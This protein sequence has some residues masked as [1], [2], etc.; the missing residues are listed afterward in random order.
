MF[1]LAFDAKSALQTPTQ[2]ASTES[3]A[4]LSA[5]TASATSQAQRQ[6]EKPL[7]NFM[8]A[9]GWRWLILSASCILISACQKP[10]NTG[11][12]GYAEGEYLYLA[13][14]VA[15]RLQQLSVQSGQTVSAGMTLAEFA[16]GSE[17]L[18]LQEA[19]QRQLSAAALAS[20]SD[21]GRR[22]SEIAALQ[23]QQLAAQ[24]QVALAE[25]E[26]ARQQQLL[27]Q[28]YISAARVD[29]AQTQLNLA[30][31]KLSEIRANLQTARLP[32]RSDERQAQYATAAA[33]A[34]LSAQQAWRVEQKRLN[35]PAAGIITQV[36][37]RA[38]EWVNA[39]QPVLA[40]LPATHRKA[41]FYVAQQELAQFQPGQ[42]VYLHC[43]GCAK[44]IP[45]KISYIATE[46]EYTPPVI[47]SNQQ[48]NKLVFLLEA[49]PYAEFAEQLRPGQPLDV[50]LTANS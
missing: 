5:R 44:R 11:W 41:R 36:Y 10:V 9:T 23:A 13:S 37:F 16:A 24:Q 3:N 25:R 28:N 31:Q 21:K 38:G 4:A 46:A 8:L 27:R 7:P 6:T 33:N 39:S 29:E 14:P 19:Q 42:T 18:A 1:C 49:R 30:Q 47:Y 48:R 22:P 2:R 20:N 15:G 32:A 17:E 12:S 34:A 45:A 35:A 50:Y 26:L 40:L 43:D